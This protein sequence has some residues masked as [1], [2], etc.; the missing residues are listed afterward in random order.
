MLITCGYRQ[1]MAQVSAP[2]D[3]FSNYPVKAVF[4]GNPAPPVLDAPRVRLYR[5]RIRDGVSKGVVFAGHYEITVWGCGAGCL[6]FAIIDAFTGKVSFFPASVS[7]NREAGER[8]TYRQ[9]SRA[10]HVIGSLNEGNSADRWYQWN[11]DK[12]VLISEKPPLVD[13]NGDPIKP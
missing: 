10:I 7:Q 5:T 3:L 6:S 2:G 12:F 1:T 11:E 13:D 9:D 4:R 8:L